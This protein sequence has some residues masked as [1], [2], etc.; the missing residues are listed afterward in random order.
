ME[1]G[2]LSALSGGLFIAITVIYV[3][4]LR[5]IFIDDWVKAVENGVNAVDKTEPTQYTGMYVLA[6]IVI[7]LGIAIINLQSGSC[8]GSSFLDDVYILGWAMLPW[9]AIFGLTVNILGSK[10]FGPSWRR[11]FSGGVLHDFWG[12]D[13]VIG[14]NTFFSKCC[15]SAE[16]DKNALYNVTSALDLGTYL[17]TVS[18]PGF[19]NNVVSE[20]PVDASFYPTKGGSGNCTPT[21][22][23]PIAEQIARGVA[24]RDIWANTIWYIMSG[25]LSVVMYATAIANAKCELSPDQMKDIYESNM[26]AQVEIDAESKNK[27]IYV[28][29]D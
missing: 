2:N 20:C 16:G 18:Q 7:Q 22:I 9:I 10:K 1:T 25:S 8:K 27:K 19:L 5:S 28:S 23:K 15:K 6:V 14:V 29:H 21:S 12:A 17:D 24:K 4:F 11:P 26:K 3:L 13:A